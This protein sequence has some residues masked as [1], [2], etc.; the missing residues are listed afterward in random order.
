MFDILGC[1]YLNA[2]PGIK[3]II[4]EVIAL[5]LL[6]VCGLYMK[7]IILLYIYLWDRLNSVNIV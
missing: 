7:L 3:H 5:C 2:H 4:T 1:C 6:T